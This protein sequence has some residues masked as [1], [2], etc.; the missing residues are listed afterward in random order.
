MIEGEAARYL[1]M[2]SPDGSQEI[3][4]DF[5]RLSVV[6]RL[7]LRGR[8]STTGR[9][10]G[11]QREPNV[12]G[13]LT[14]RPQREPVLVFNM[15]SLS[16]SR[17]M[18]RQGMAPLFLGFFF[19]VVEADG[20]D[21]QPLVSSELVIAQPPKYVIAII[22]YD[23]FTSIFTHINSGLIVSATE[24]RRQDS[25]PTVVSPNGSGALTARQPTNQAEPERRIELHVP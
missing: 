4:K 7:R 17:P 13:K 18:V 24:L 10:M 9:G 15:H 25:G 16:I 14:D 12:R 3:L 20:R 2:L 1:S 22:R 8:E 19:L 23:K 5:Q 6:T 11:G 21:E